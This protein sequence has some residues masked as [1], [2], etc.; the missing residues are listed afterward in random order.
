MLVETGPKLVNSVPKKCR[1]NSVQHLVSIRAEFRRLRAASGGFGRICPRL[2]HPWP[3]LGEIRPVWARRYLS[4]VAYICSPSPDTA[5]KHQLGGPSVRGSP[6]CAHLKTS[7]S[8]VE[9]TKFNRFTVILK[10]GSRELER[11]RKVRT[12]GKCTTFGSRLSAT[13]VTIGGSP[14]ELR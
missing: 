2:G 10:L 7:Q 14:P 9:P 13:E 6:P 5:L 4:S 8:V 11:T 12:S 1:P 3:E